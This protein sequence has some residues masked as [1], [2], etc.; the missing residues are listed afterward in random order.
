MGNDIS[1]NASLIFHYSS[2]RIYKR[3]PIVI[4]SIS[5]SLLIG[6]YHPVKPPLLHSWD[7]VEL[8]SSL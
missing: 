6:M 1:P 2:Q 7:D 4:R 5:G 3:P 8:E